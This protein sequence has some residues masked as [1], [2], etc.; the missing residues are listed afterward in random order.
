MFGGLRRTV[1]RLF[2]TPRPLLFDHVP[3]CAGTT[4]S[5]YLS[6]Q[7]PARTV[8]QL[9]ED[10]PEKSLAKFRALPESRRHGFRLIAGHEAHQLLNLVDPS[11][12]TLTILREPVDRLVSHY[13]YVKRNIGHYLHQRLISEQ[14]TLEDYA[15]PELSPELSNWY[16]IH[17]SGLPVA[18]VQADPFGALERA[19]TN[20]I[21][22]YDVIGF[23]DELPET[24]AAVRRIVGLEKAFANTFLN[25]TVNRER[26]ED[27]SPL[28][29]KRIIEANALDI[30]LYER[31]NA[32]CHRRPFVRS[33]RAFRSAP[34]LLS[35]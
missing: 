15:S 3:K 1:S 30:E 33:M 23:Q 18:E 12:L 5:A 16:T 35:G 17:Y 26:V 7:Y 22:H 20:V 34:A 29:K 24:M 11:V 2:Q 28:A 10:T 31:L 4:V 32:L 8:F 9:N 21:E 19:Y 27:V 25:Q 6:S 14:I 13:Y